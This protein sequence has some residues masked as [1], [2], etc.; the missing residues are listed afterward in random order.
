MKVAVI[1]GGTVGKAVARTYLEFVDEVRVW[2]VRPER[3]TVDEVD[4]ALDCDIVFLCLPTPQHQMGGGLDVSAV[5]DLCR[6]LPGSF[7]SANL[8]LKSTVPVGTTRRLAETYGLKNLVHSPEFLTARCAEIDARIPSI[9]VIGC[10]TSTNGCSD[11]L[12][13]MYERRFPGTKLIV[14]TSNTSE[15]AKLAINSWFAVKVS[16]FNEIKSFCAM[17]GAGWERVREIILADGRTTAHHTQVPGPDG[18]DGFGGVCLPKDLAQFIQ[19]Y[20]N[21][22]D[23][24]TQGCPVAEAA[25]FRNA[26]IDRGEVV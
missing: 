24:G 8:V 5:E 16:M 18:K 13:Y 14:T 7:P 1:G 9:N 6:Q 4:A 22:T 25:R 11:K 3:R 23:G 19:E 10:P 15:A 21:H 20:W 2:D 12:K 26:Q 17:V